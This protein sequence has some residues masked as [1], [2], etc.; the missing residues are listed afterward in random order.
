MVGYSG[1]LDNG[2][3]LKR[4]TLKEKLLNGMVLYIDLKASYNFHHNILSFL[5]L[6]EIF[7]SPQVKRI[8]INSNKH[9]IYEFSH[10]FPSDLRLRT[11]RN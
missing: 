4:Q 7:L 6:D 3:K 11:L 9:G 1:I 8:K 5:M 2:K 10:E